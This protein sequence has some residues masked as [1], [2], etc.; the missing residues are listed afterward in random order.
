MRQI[1]DLTEDKVSRLSRAVFE[2]VGFDREVSAMANVAQRIFDP[3]NGL[4]TKEQSGLWAYLTAPAFRGT[5]SKNTATKY[6]RLSAQLGLAPVVEVPDGE[7]VLVRLDYDRG[8][9]VLR[10]A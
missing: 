4:D 2:R 10:A 1:G 5:V 7:G 6:R 8:T 3:T 9:E